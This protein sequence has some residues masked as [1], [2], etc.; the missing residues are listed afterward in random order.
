MASLRVA[1][2]LRVALPARSAPLPA[3]APCASHMSVMSPLYLL[4]ILGRQSVSGRGKGIFRLL[5]IVESRGVICASF[6]ASSCCPSAKALSTRF[7]FFHFP[8][9]SPTYH[10]TSR[11]S[12]PKTK[13]HTV[14]LVKSPSWI[15]VAESA[16]AMGYF[17]QLYIEIYIPR[18]RSICTVSGNLHLM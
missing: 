10:F 7:F 15:S 18:T 9:L 13:L 14:W 16:K 5:D 6:K 4:G 1:L 8:I 3:C 11:W 17:W 12:I 2:R